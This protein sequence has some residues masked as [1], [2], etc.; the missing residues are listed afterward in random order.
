MPVEHQTGPFTKHHYISVT[1]NRMNVAQLLDFARELEE[2][3]AD[4][5]LY[6]DYASDRG[7][8]NRLSVRWDEE[9][10]DNHAE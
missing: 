1:S 10:A 5:K 4:P 8:L 6:V 3:Y 7:I 9:L 2:S